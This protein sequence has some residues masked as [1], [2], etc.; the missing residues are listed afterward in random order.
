VNKEI[1]QK[2]IYKEKNK[3]LIFNIKC[4]GAKSKKDNE[5]SA[6]DKIN[7]NKNRFLKKSE[8]LKIKKDSLFT[9]SYISLVF[10][11]KFIG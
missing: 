7:K 9:A 11:L 8:N 4:P 3:T 5:K 6:I 10:K 2:Q 1:F